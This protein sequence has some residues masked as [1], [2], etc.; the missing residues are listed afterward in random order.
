M[1][2]FRLRPISPELESRVY[3]DDLQVTAGERF[4][5]MVNRSTWISMWP[6]WFSRKQVSMPTSEFY[7]AQA[8]LCRTFALKQIQRHA[9][10]GFGLCDGTH[11]QS[12]KGRS[13]LNPEILEAVL[14]T[15]GV[16]AADF[17]Y[18][19]IDA[20]YHSNSGGQTQRASDVWLSDADYL[21][22]VVDPYSL[23]QAHAKW[24]DTIS[25]ADWKDYLRDNG[26]KSVD[27]IPEGDYL[28]G[29]NEK[30]KVF[31]PG[32]GFLKDDQDQGRLGI[33]LLLF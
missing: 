18:K 26:M 7:K 27:R 5:T 23:H 24:Q 30:E 11:C 31:H 14:A 16:I 12:Y 19:L 4:I 33:S 25:F 6:G 10:E 3:D 28:C 22:A 17:N 13:N 9:T 32:Q 20:A 1:Q 21:Q 8:V 15:T 29:A 2:L